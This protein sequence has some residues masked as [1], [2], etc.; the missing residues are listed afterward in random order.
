MEEIKLSFQDLS[1]F[2]VIANLVLGVLFGSLPLIA[3]LILKKR[4]YAW[5]GFLFSTLGGALLGVFLSYPI[6]AIFL[7][8]ITRSP[9]PAD[10]VLETVDS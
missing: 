2:I 6:A 3:G 9:K 8:L 10:T 4:K 5:L 7:W 1:Y